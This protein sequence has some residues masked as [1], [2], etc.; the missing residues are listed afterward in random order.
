MPRGM[1]KDEAWKAERQKQYNEDVHHALATSRFEY[2]MDLAQDQSQIQEELQAMEQQAQQLAMDQ[3][4]EESRIQAER[5]L[6]DARDH[7]GTRRGQYQNE[8]AAETEQRRRRE[9]LANA[10]EQWHSQSAASSGGHMLPGCTTWSRH[11]VEQKGSD[12]QRGSSSI[13]R[14]RPEDQR[15]SRHDEEQKDQQRCHRGVGAA[16]AAAEDA[17]CAEAANEEGTHDEGSRSGTDPEGTEGGGR[18]VR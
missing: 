9:G 4:M 11:N 2:D 15:R 6:D 14:N 12:G 13:S 17:T 18:S 16:E 7:A 5:R 3:A 1:G 10:T 8:T